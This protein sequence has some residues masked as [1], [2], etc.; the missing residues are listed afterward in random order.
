VVAEV[1]ED[2]VL[3][4][5]HVEPATG[6][7]AWGPPL[8]GADL[9][10]AGEHWFTTTPGERVEVGLSRDRA[11][12]DLLS[13]LDSGLA[14]AIDYGHVTGGRPAHGT[15]T[16]YREGRLTTPVPDGSCD[17]TAHVAMDSL[18]HDELVD[19]RTALLRLGVSGATPPVELARTD[20]TAYLRA[21]EDAGAAGALTARGGFGDF[22]WAF[23]RRG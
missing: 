4:E 5:R 2:T 17:L 20:P 7:E 13:R 14:V 1:D 3:R 8:A 22:L 11:W 19:Q 15:L 23:K 12:A 9:A 6:A 18:D 10:W 16:A 21:L